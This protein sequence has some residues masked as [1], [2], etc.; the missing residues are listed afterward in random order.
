M[1]M[2]IDICI[3]MRIDMRIGMRIGMLVDMCID[4]RTDMRRFASRHVHATAKDMLSAMPIQSRYRAVISRR[5]YVGSTRKA[6]LA[7]SPR[8]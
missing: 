2:C 6:L 7:S 1:D 4:V 3:D 8:P 5:H